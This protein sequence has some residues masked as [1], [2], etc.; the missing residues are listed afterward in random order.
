MKWHF[1][2]DSIR[3]K[4]ISLF[5]S[6]SCCLS[7]T[8]SSSIF[9]YKTDHVGRKTGNYHAKRLKLV[10]LHDVNIASDTCNVHIYIILYYNSIKTYFVSMYQNK[11]RQ[12]VWKM[13][14]R[15][16]I[17]RMNANNFIGQLNGYITT[18]YFVHELR[19]RMM[20]WHLAS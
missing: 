17:A 1:A 16:H 10:W 14:N 12:I 4:W 6:I 7:A 18:E 20:V 9:Y 13:I 19:R 5:L 11:T 2:F 15:Y 8:S 3:R